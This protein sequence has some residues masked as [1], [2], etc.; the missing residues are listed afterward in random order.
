MRHPYP[1]QRPGTEPTHFRQ[2][3]AGAH[4]ERHQVTAGALEALPPTGLE[5]QAP[6]FG[7]AQSWLLQALGEVNPLPPPH[8]TYQIQRGE[9]PLLSHLHCR[10]TLSDG[11]VYKKASYHLAWVWV[12]SSSHAC[13]T[14]IATCCMSRT[15]ANVAA[16]A[17]LYHSKQQMHQVR[18][19]PPGPGLGPP[20]VLGKC[21][22]GARACWWPGQAWARG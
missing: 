6:C 19:R 16:Q 7:L 12:F 8:S 21:G 14:M 4:P 5:S 2:L 9:I 17:A 10:P 1:V 20:G 15:R 11:R 22:P 3:P 13:S 18:T